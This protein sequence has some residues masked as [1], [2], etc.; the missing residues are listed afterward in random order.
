MLIPSFS[1]DRWN[2]A[3]TKEQ[4]AVTVFP[5]KAIFGAQVGYLPSGGRSIE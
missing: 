1:L 4:L 3:I 2:L 5:L